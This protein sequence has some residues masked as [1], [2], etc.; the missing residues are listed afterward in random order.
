MELRQLNV[1]EIKVIF[2]QHIKNDFPISEQRP[3]K[4]IMQLKHKKQYYC[5]GLYDNDLV[6]YAFFAGDK[7]KKVL[8]L[9]YFAVVKEKRN[10]GYGSI[11]VALIKEKFSEYLIIAEVES[12]ITARNISEKN[13]RQRRINFYLDNGLYQSDMICQLFGVHYQML[14]FNKEILND[15]IL[16][17][18][19]KALYLSIYPYLVYLLF[20]KIRR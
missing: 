10:S 6:G 15:F 18:Q 2:H 12:I 5:F 20:I 3:L 4:S 16:Y 19:L 11:F 9:D 13:L 1:E 8:L 17:H 7:N 14:Y